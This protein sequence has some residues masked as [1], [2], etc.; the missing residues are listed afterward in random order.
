M[1]RRKIPAGWYPDTRRR[2]QHR[3][4]DGREWTEHTMPTSAV[5]GPP[6]PGPRPGRTRRGVVAGPPSVV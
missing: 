5:P 6:P 3:W 4:F 1:A 2:G